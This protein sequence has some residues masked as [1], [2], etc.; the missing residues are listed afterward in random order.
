MLRVPFRHLMY[1]DSVSNNET[2]GEHPKCP[3]KY[4]FCLETEERKY[5]LF[6]RNE[7]EHFLW[8]T[9]FYRIAKVEVI[10]MS[11]QP[12]LDILKIYDH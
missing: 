9:A 11:Y 7:E 4:Q 10:D 12:S 8:L 2:S 5:L 3:W 6:A 1:I